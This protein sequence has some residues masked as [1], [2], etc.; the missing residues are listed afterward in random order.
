MARIGNFKFIEPEAWRFSTHGDVLDAKRRALGWQEAHGS[1][2]GAEFSIE[3]FVRQWAL[4]ELIEA[5]DYPEEWIGERIIIEEPVKTGSTE[6]EAD[7]SIKN[8]GRR[9]FLYI[10]AKKRGISDDEFNEVPSSISWCLSST[11]ASRS[12]LISWRTASAV[13]HA[14]RSNC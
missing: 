4:N 6:K 8:A 1:L 3:E 12:G 9:T 13:L 11:S 7:I 2:E 10:E 5:Y 14:H